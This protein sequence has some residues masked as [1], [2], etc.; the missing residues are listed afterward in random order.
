LIILQIARSKEAWS[1]RVGR[2][3][4]V[5]VV[6]IDKGVRKSSAI[7]LMEQ[8]IESGFLTH[9]DQTAKTKADEDHLCQVL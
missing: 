1:Y 7:S 3:A 9:I 8:K 2:S 4:L 6:G 5:T